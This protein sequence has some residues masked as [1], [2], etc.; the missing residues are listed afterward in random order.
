[1]PLFSCWCYTGRRFLAA[2]KT[3]CSLRRGSTS[4]YYLRLC[5]RHLCKY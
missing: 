2:V 5:L 3:Y 4:V 1:M